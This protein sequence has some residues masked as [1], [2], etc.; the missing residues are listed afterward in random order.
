VPPIHPK[1]MPVILREDDWDRWL[2]ADAADALKYSDRGP[3]MDR[4]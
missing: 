3:M 1:A 2:I 4:K